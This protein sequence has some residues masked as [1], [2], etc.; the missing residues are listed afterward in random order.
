[1]PGSDDEPDPHEEW[2]LEE[3]SESLTTTSWT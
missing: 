2:D 3:D 1:M